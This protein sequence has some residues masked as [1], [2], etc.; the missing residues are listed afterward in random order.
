MI[1]NE[2]DYCKSTQGEQ[3]HNGLKYFMESFLGFKGCFI[4]LAN[5]IFFFGSLADTFFIHCIIG[6][7]KSNTK[8]QMSLKVFHCFYNSNIEERGRL[9]LFLNC[10][11][12]KKKLGL[13]FGVWFLVTD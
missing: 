5:E 2:I 12:N 4:N 1:I 3:G 6:D 13:T 11:S 7:K 10:Y 9:H 8:H